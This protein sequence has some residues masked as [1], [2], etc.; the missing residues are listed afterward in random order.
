M[1]AYCASATIQARIWGAIIVVCFTVPS[2]VAFCTYAVIAVH[3]ILKKYIWFHQM[4][5]IKF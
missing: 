5:H 4:F 1:I 3:H 2:S